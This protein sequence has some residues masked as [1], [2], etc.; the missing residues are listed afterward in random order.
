[1]G[2]NFEINIPEIPGISINFMQPI[3][4]EEIRTNASE[5]IYQQKS[6]VAHI[7]FVPEKRP[8]WRQIKRAMRMAG[9]DQHRRFIEKSLRTQ[10]V[11]LDL[12]GVCNGKRIELVNMKPELHGG[13]MAFTIGGE[14]DG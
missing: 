8:R 14:Q 2:D 5:P 3:K 11:K 10:G 7:T 4:V 13:N 12:I 6:L 9:T 1:M